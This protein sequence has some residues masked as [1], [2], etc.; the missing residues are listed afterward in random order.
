MMDKELAVKIIDTAK[1][2]MSGDNCQPF[3]FRFNL[4][5]QTFHVDY[6]ADKAKHALVYDDYT[7]AITL[8][9]LLTYI[10][11]SLEEHSFSSDVEFNLAN[12]SPFTS[13]ESVIALKVIK[14]G[15]QSKLATKSLY[16]ALTKRA[17]DRRPYLP[18]SFISADETLLNNNLQLS[19]CKLIKNIPQDLLNFLSNCDCTVWQ[20]KGLG[21]D[22]MNSVAFDTKSETGLPWRNLGL[23]KAEVFPIK[24]IQFHHVFFDL[25]KFIGARLM[26]KFAQKK[27][28]VSSQSALV[29]SVQ[30]GMSLEEKVNASSEMFNV[31][32]NLTNLGYAFQPSTLS[33][34][35]LN[36]D[37]KP[38]LNIFSATG[39]KAPYL[40][41]DV[42]KYRKLLSVETRE[43][44]WIL[45]IGKPSGDLPNN[46]KTNRLDTSKILSFE[47]E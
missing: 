35:I 29:F 8:G 30:A 6:L 4:S 7:I 3:R 40:Q 12:F 19:Q 32:L 23:S 14:S 1:Y 36:S 37:I 42:A 11:V 15:N 44:Q 20:S 26:M 5:T 47:E 31:L 41:S 25:L 38:K 34:E 39:I 43:I 16:Q 45:R 46:S 18:A 28:W 13:Q 10:L 2:Y 33:T 22:I 17:V 27:L 24:L 21:L 9:S